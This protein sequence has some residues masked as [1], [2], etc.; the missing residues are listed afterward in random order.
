MRK[1]F[2]LLLRGKSG[3]VVSSAGLFDHERQAKLAVNDALRECPQATGWVIVETVKTVV[4]EGEG[5][6]LVR[7][8]E[9]APSSL[10]RW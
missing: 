9:P 7:Q 6:I 10:G 1:K 2:E 8:S 4:A 3:K 5:L